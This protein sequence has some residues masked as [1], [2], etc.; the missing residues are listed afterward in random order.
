MSE[1]SNLNISELCGL[2]IPQKYLPIVS[3]FLFIRMWPDNKVCGLITVGVLHASLL[4]VTVVAFKVLPLGSYA[5]VP[6]PGPP[7]KTVLELVLWNDLQSCRHVF[8]MEEKVLLTK[9]DQD[10]QQ[11]AELEKTSQKFVKLCVKII[12]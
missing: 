8:L 1:D 10:T 6:A 9:R 7:F 12:G 2:N 3:D 11:Q 5:P 4:N